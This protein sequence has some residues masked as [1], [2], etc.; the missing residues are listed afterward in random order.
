[1]S[2]ST[3]LLQLGWR[4]FFQQQLSYEEWETVCVARVMAHHRTGFLL[5]M[6]QQERAEPKTLTLPVTSELPNMTVGDWILLDQQHRFVRLLDRMSEFTRK[7]AGSKVQAQ[8]IATNVDTVF[9]V[10]SLN[11]DFNLSRIER[12]LTL[13]HEAGAEPVV[14][15]TKSDC[16]DKPDDYIR[17]VR[18]LEPGLMVE[19]V[20]GLERSSVAILEPWCSRGNTVAFL[21]SSGVGKST[22]VNTLLGNETQLTAGIREDDGKGRHTTTS[23]ALNIMPAGGLLL[24]TPGMRELQLA[25]SEQGIAEA[26]SDITALTEKC[27]FSDCQ[28]QTEP[29]CAV[30]AA[31]EAGGLEQRRL[32]NYQKLNREQARNGA[33]LAETRSQNRKLTKMYRSVQGE[34]RNRK[35]A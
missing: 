12:Y 33:T 27:R 32:K 11:D 22:L 9:V 8:I 5:A 20:N 25:A 6:D 34:A 2:N 26:F 1:M 18:A 7:A 10:C 29:N 16:C 4:P 15:L 24:D 17:E 30:I 13:V 14:V 23:R 28:H 31:V 3:I 35:K 19:A 21:G